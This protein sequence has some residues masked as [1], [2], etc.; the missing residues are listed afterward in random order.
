MDQVEFRFSSRFKLFSLTAILLMLVLG[1]SGFS[2][3]SEVLG[4]IAWDNDSNPVNP[5]SGNPY[6]QLICLNG[7]LFVEMIQMSI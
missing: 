5:A 2:P 4:D 6:N 3:T 1:S 7:R